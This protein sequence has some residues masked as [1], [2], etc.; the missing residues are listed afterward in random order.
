M[1]ELKVSVYCKRQLRDI[2][3]KSPDGKL[4]RRAQMLLWLSDGVS[5]AEVANRMRITR[6]AVYVLVW[7]FEQRHDLPV[8]ERLEDSDGRGRSAELRNAV[9]ER[10]GIMF[11]TNPETYGYR[12]T[13]WTIPMLRTQLKAVLKR[14]MS[15]DTIRRA[16]KDM[17]F[18]YKRPRF[19]LSRQSPTWRNAKGGFVEA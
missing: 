4:V 19:V 12:T 7:R 5:K 9:K 17:N 3:Q 8:V 1:S 16:L 15:D 13:C 2:V 14:S 10:L 11:R 18:S 6:Q